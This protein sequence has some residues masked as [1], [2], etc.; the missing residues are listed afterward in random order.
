[1]ADKAPL[2]RKK[3]PLR[4]NF[5]NLGDGNEKDED[6]SGARRRTR[7]SHSIG[8]PAR[9]L[10]CGLLHAH[11]LLPGEL[12]RGLRVRHVRGGDGHVHGD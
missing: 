1:M 2:E 6:R 3:I 5:S 9:S 12:L 7:R 11:E 4:L 10:R 8:L